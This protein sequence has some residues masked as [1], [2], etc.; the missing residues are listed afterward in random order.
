MDLLLEST[1]RQLQHDAHYEAK[2]NVEKHDDSRYEDSEG[3]EARTR[4]FCWFNR[5]G[6]RT[7]V[8]SL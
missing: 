2:K 3:D 1:W 8:C 6:R 5:T 7:S 4:K